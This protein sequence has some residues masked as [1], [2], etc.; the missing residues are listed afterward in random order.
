MWDSNPRP[1]APEVEGSVSVSRCYGAAD[2]L[3]TDLLALVDRVR[4]GE[5]ISRA[6]GAAFARSAQALAAE[7]GRAAE[8]LEV[9]P[10]GHFHARLLDLLELALALTRAAPAACA[11]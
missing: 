6:E 1:L 9:A 2:G 8:A 7:L 3:R 5:A 10:D 4:H 11:S